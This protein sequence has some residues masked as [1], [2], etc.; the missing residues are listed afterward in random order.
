VKNQAAWRTSKFEWRGGR[1]RTARD[2]AE[3]GVGSRLIT[4]AVARVYG[5]QLPLHA[6]GALL[7]L[8]CGKVPLYGAYR[9]MV[10]EVTCVD[11]APSEPVDHLDLRCDLTQP[12]PLGD[13]VFDTIVLSDVLEHIPEPAQLWSEMARMLTPGGKILMNVP[14]FYWL[15]AHPHDYYRYTNFALERFVERSG[16]QLLT[17]RPLGGVLDVLADML[18]KLLDKIPL[19]GTP[20]ALAL[21]GLVG[22]FGR[23]GP[24]A[25]LATVSARHF[26]L[27]Y[28]LVAQKPAAA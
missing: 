13:G 22:A 16:L 28:F 14:F 24:G 18:A 8:G 23:T 12:L 26:P 3:V 25:R 17:L 15:H 7:D 20:L 9:D 21:Q 10:G 1:W 2:A 5:E 6:R 27:G 4:D 11:W 19:I